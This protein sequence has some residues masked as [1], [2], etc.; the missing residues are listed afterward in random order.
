LIKLEIRYY[1][2]MTVKE[3]FKSVK[4]LRPSDKARLVDLILTDLDRPNQEVEK[5][6][7]KEVKDR[8]SSVKSGKTKM[9][10]YQQVMGKYK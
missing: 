4:D 3:L 2:N 5:E 9:L 6:W 7:I 10:S 1:K 8:K